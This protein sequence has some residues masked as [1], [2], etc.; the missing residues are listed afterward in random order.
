MSPNSVT[1]REHPSGSLRMVMCHFANQ[2]KCRPYTLRGENI[3]ELLG[4]I[5]RLLPEGPPLMAEDEY[6][7]QTERALAEEVIRE[8]IFLKMR[9]EIPYSTA[10]KIE[11][12]TD[13]PERNLKRIS[14]LVLVERE[15]YKGMLIGAGG[16]TLKEIGT[17]ARLELE[18]MLGARVFL[19]TT[20]RV[21][22]GWTSDPR[23][24][25]ELGL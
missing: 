22:P 10:V 23:K 16:R 1:F 2:E 18:K 14:A 25:A 4:V 6:T 9:Q 12:F 3:E 11:S 19:E 13:E 5:R 8:K 20:V 15:S 7:D 21:E 17:A 24:L